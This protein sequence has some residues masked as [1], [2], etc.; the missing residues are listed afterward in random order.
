VHKYVTL[1][2]AYTSIETKKSMKI[3]SEHYKE[4]EILRSVTRRCLEM[5]EKRYSRTR[6]T[7]PRNSQIS[8]PV[9]VVA[10]WIVYVFPEPVCP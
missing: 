9:S 5:S 2:E 10:P 4:N 8:S 6:G 1:E 3:N 7:R